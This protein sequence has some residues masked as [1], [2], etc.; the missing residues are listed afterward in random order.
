MEWTFDFF[1]LASVYDGSRSEPQNARTM[2]TSVPKAPRFFRAASLP[3]RSLDR[4][5]FFTL[6]ARGFSASATFFFAL[7]FGES[8]AFAF[9]AQLLPPRTASAPVRRDR[10]LAE[11]SARRASTDRI[12][13]K[14]AN[15]S[16]NER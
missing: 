2:S 15:H 1:A 9:G 10:P 3:S 8:G 12:I 13:C 6:G 4:R 16:V 7:L 11:A 14:F 5:A